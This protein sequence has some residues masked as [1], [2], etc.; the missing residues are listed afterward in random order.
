MNCMYNPMLIGSISLVDRA[1]ALL[2]SSQLISFRLTICKITDIAVKT[3]NFMINLWTQHE[4][5]TLGLCLK[6][7]SGTSAYLRRPL[8]PWQGPSFQTHQGW[9]YKISWPEVSVDPSSGKE[10]V[11]SLQMFSNWGAIW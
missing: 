8:G 3:T 1:R 7:Q 4:T 2:Y 9:T 10:L 11:S 6:V 5:F